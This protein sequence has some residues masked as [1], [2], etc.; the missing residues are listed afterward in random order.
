MKFSSV[1]VLLLVDVM[2]TR[3]LD[4]TVKSFSFGIVQSMAPDK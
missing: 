4:D 1:G 2:Y 3:V